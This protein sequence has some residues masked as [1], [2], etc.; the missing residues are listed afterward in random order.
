LGSGQ[1]IWNHL[2]KTKERLPPKILTRHNII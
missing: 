1:T 2:E